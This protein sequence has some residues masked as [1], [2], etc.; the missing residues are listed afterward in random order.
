M[1]YTAGLGV[2][3]VTFYDFIIRVDY[4]FNQLGENGLFLHIKGDF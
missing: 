1:L 4:S 2:D 3:V